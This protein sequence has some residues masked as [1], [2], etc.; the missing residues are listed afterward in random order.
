MYDNDCEYSYA[1]S[2]SSVM[3][4]LLQGLLGS[5][6]EAG[7]L[8]YLSPTLV[9]FGLVR[10]CQS[11]VCHVCLAIRALGGANAWQCFS[12]ARLLDTSLLWSS[13]HHL[14]P[15]LAISQA[16]DTM[17]TSQ[18]QKFH[19]EYDDNGGD[20]VLECTDDVLFR[21]HSHVLRSHRSVPHDPPGNTQKLN[22]HSLIFQNMLEQPGMVPQ[23]PRDPPTPINSPSETVKIFVDL[24]Q[25]ISL[26]GRQFPLSQLQAVLPL[27]DAFSTYIAIDRLVILALSRA[28]LEP[29]QLFIFASAM[30]HFL[31]TQKDATGVARAAISH[32]TTRW[33]T[34][35]G[36]SPSRMVA[37]EASRLSNKYLMALIVACWDVRRRMDLELNEQDK[38]LGW[39]TV[40]Q[41]FCPK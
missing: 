39:D 17:S 19:S 35:E 10:F 40:A 29:W 33:G 28:E 5:V 25:N 22:L 38:A 14:L 11:C 26:T 21:V 15:Y 30:D 1:S 6:K 2:V 18:A 9:F 3:S 23:G 36:F 31:I 7:T 27:I 12:P 24:M 16:S 32:F 34:F 13:Q 37:A 4:G 8:I 41:T 20:I